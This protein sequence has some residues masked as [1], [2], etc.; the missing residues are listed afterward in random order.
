MICRHSRMRG[1]LVLRVRADSRGIGNWEGF[2]IINKKKEGCRVDRIKVLHKLRI[3]YFQK[4]QVKVILM[5]RYQ[6]IFKFKRKRW[7]IIYQLKELNLLQV[8]IVVVLMM[9][10]KV[11]FIHFFNLS[12]IKINQVKNQLII[13]FGILLSVVSVAVLINLATKN[14]LC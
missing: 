8:I 3:N 14:P 6:G 5:I 11:K 9:N 12:W 13:K 2:W 7:M 10:K 4:G 1:V